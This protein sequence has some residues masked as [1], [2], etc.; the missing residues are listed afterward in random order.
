[1]KR[2][3][4]RTENHRGV[5]NLRVEVSA[6]RGDKGTRQVSRGAPVYNKG[7]NI[8][9]TFIKGT[10]I[11][12]LPIKP[13][14]PG[15]K[16][17]PAENGH[18]R[19]EPPSTKQPP[20]EEQRRT[21]L[22][23]Y[24]NSNLGLQRSASHMMTGQHRATNSRLLQGKAHTAHTPTVAPSAALRHE[25]RYV[26]GRG[27][28]RQRSCV[29]SLYRPQAQPP[30][31]MLAAHNP[32][33]AP[34]LSRPKPALQLYR[35]PNDHGSAK[36]GLNINAKEFVYPGEGA[37]PTSPTLRHSKSSSQVIRPKGAAKP[38]R[39]GTG[40]AR[41]HFTDDSN[42]NDPDTT[43]GMT[44]APPL[45]RSKS[46]GAADLGRVG[47]RSAL[48]A[49]SDLG[50]LD[51]DLEAALAAVGRDPQAAA[52][53]RVMAAVRGLL[54]RALAA[55]SLAP[56]VSRYC[57]AVI[58]K[59]GSSEVFLDTLLNSCQEYFQEYQRAALL[60]GTSWTAYMT[61]L[62]ELYSQM[63]R[64]QRSSPSSSPAPPA[65][66]LLTLLA[67]C[68]VATLS[69]SAPPSLAQTETLFLT[70]TALG[71]DMEAAL[72]SL[73]ARLMDAARDAVFTAEKLPAVKK[74]LMQLIEMSAA[75]WQIPASA[76]VYYYPTASGV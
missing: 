62:H 76:V 31:N 43:V 22:K 63:K 10:N 17:K 46:M 57:A 54:A 39:T 32:A 74:T 66:R 4:E 11:E 75:S 45:L 50:P 36:P 48:A 58:E 18:A 12:I 65:H 13:L 72:P 3:E 20:K 35:P 23:S 55:A 16:K 67:E 29:A 15:A 60:E 69:R 6:G 38:G 44:S 21:L 41:V 33:P 49:L 53:P 27:V 64:L 28:Q 71:R 8:A 5:E 24:S 37:S 47:G 70:L 42:S 73:M 1:M 51:A 25:D 59:E 7:A 19:K 40:A 34:V 56:A 30:A 61:L 26:N 14:G 2:A 9:P 52:A 68:C